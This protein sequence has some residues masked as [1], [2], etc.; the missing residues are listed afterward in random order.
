MF[1]RR[2]DSPERSSRWC[3]RFPRQGVVR[4]RSARVGSI[5][6][7]FAAG[8]A[9]A[10]VAATLKQFP[11]VGRALRSTDRAAITIDAS[12][13]ALADDLVP[14]RRA[15]A[16]GAPVVML[17][18]A[19]CPAY[20]DKPA[21]W[22]GRIQALLRGALR[23]RGVTITDALEAAAYTHRR[24][25]ASVAVLAAQAGVDLILVTG[26]EAESEA[27]YR[28]LLARAASG[29]IAPASLRRSYDRVLSLRRQ[30]G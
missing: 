3:W 5:A 17:S 2:S 25:S 10:G 19:T 9:D 20:G 11:G 14:F 12:A 30:L 4:P 23:F 18:N 26:S 13:G 29:S 8:L 28:R 15:I 1:A 16:A 24:S 22:S 7:A 6:T 27:V 21:S